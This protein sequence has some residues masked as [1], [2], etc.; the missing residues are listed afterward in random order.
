MHGDAAVAGQ[1]VAYES[2]L[3]ARTTWPVGPMTK[4]TFTVPAAA[5]L[6]LSAAS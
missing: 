4:C 6:R 1:G 5:A 2:S 3:L